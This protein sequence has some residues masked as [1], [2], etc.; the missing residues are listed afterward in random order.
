[1]K[2]I[3][4]KD[5]SR[6]AAIKFVVLLGIISLFSDMTYESARSINGPFLALL[7]ATGTIVGII[8][9]TGELVGYGLRLFSG[10]LADKSKQY[11]IITFFGYFLNLLAVPLLALAGNW[12]LAAT[13]MIAERAGKA[14][15]NPPRDAMLSHATFATGRGWGFGLHAALD[16]VGAVVGPLFVALILFLHGDYRTGYVFLI[17]PAVLG[18]IT[19][20]VAHYFYPRPEDLEPVGKKIETKGFTSSYWFYLLAA[21]CIAAGFADFPLIAFHFQKGAI[22]PA[23]VIPILYAIAMALEGLTGIIVGRLFDKIG[24]KV[25]VP[26]VFLAAFFA[27]FVFLGNFT[28]ALVGMI[29]WG[30][31]MGVQG[32]VIKAAVSEVIPSHKRSTGFGVFDTG[33]G[34]AWFL[35]SVAMGILY[36]RSIPALIIF[37]VILQLISI[38][39]FLLAKKSS[40]H[41]ALS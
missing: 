19:L 11:W 22:A 18:L 26:A 35:G 39:I 15:R 36:D 10:L 27:P 23:S 29:L 6:S 7:G 34:V 5:I 25:L 37:S 13:L 41:E 30:I 33:F 40:A 20:F 2:K 4:T 8:A 12:P 24:N 31:G 21:V 1:M 32:S 9:G 3:H 17:I 14:M 28:M 16:Q 38:P